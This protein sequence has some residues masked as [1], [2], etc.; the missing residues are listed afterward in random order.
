MGL[1]AEKREEIRHARSERARRRLRRQSA[2]KTASL[3]LD[4][5]R[6]IERGEKG[7]DRMVRESEPARRRRLEKEKPS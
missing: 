4:P 3:E 6:V 2:H 7:L 5:V 1:P